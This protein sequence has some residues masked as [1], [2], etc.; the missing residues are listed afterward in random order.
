MLYNELGE[1]TPRSTF[2]LN[3][4]NWVDEKKRAS[5]EA[6]VELATQSA[7]LRGRQRELGLHKANG[8][9]V[10]VLC[11]P[12]RAELQ[13]RAD[14]K[15]HEEAVKMA[16][17]LPPAQRPK[18]FI[19]PRQY[20]GR[21]VAKIFCLEDKNDPNVLVDMTYFG[22]VDCISECKQ[23][24]FFIKYDDGDNEEY[25]LDDLNEALQLYKKHESEDTKK[26]QARRDD[27]VKTT[28][29]E[30][31]HS[32]SGI[33]AKFQGIS[34]RGTGDISLNASVTVARAV[35]MASPETP[36]LATHMDALPHSLP[37]VSVPPEP[38]TTT[39]CPKAHGTISASSATFA[40]E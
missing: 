26:P 19:D 13:R 31:T 27:G 37:T 25:N 29:I 1:L 9:L 21:R 18:A 20:V 22:M 36:P 34:E 40:L 11:A 16:R 7:E 15:A 23:V 10:D 39:V 5:A 2:V 30:G 35:P 4:D 12:A 33:D 28:H 8:Q 38:A 24:W 17:V 14:E 32:G 3:V 6:Q